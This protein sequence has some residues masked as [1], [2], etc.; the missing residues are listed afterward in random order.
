M[1]CTLILVNI[2]RNLVNPLFHILKNY[3]EIVLS[4]GH[5]LQS[6][7]EAWEVYL[8]PRDTVDVSDYR[9]RVLNIL[10]ILKIVSY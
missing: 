2:E 4:L 6:A 1:L 8:D 5:C 7:H 10:Q 9:V 3:M